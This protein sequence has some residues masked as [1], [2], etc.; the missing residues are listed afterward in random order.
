MKDEKKETM[1]M[2]DCIRNKRQGRNSIE[3][4]KLNIGKDE[5]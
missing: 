2:K 1:E 4:N 5:Q 3:L